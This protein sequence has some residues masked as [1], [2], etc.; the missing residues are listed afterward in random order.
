MTVNRAF[1]ITLLVLL[2]AVSAWVWPE[3]PE[4]IPAHY[5][6]DGVIDRWSETTLLSWFAMP[7]VALAMSALLYGVAALSTR[8][9]ARINLPGKERLLTLPHERQQAVL[10]R[11]RAGIEML[12]LPTTII[13]CIIQVANYR[14]A[15]GLET[16][17]LMT[18]VLIIAMAGSPLLAILLIVRVQAE[19]DRQCRAQASLTTS[20]G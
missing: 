1:N 13:F 18:A 4:R 8:S 7:L 6:A 19:I 14:G 15:H 17:G 5:G 12:A 10:A 20:R 16:G 3:L 11:L 2:F 9:V